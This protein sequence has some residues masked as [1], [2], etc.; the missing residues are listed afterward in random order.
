MQINNFGAVGNQTNVGVDEV[1]DLSAQAAD[2]RWNVKL[3]LDA[4]DDDAAVRAIDLLM[5]S[6][7]YLPEGGPADHILFVYQAW[8][9][10]VQRSAVAVRAKVSAATSMDAVVTAAA[11]VSVA[12]NG[13]RMRVIEGRAIVASDGGDWVAQVTS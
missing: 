10:D 5:A 13:A 11:L 3:M 12:L 6:D 4:T 8:R 1:N 2:M 9:G 7:S